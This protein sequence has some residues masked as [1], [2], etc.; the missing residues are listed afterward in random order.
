MQ[1][2]LYLC[3]IIVNGP[4]VNSM[5]AP[6]DILNQLRS[7]NYPS[8][9]LL[10]GEEPYYIDLVSDY[11]EHRI[12]D[13]AAQAFDLTVL[14]GRDLPGQDISPAVS[15]ARGFAMMGGVKIVLVKEAQVIKKWD[16][17]ALYMDNP[18]PGTLFAICYKYGAPDKRLNLWKSFEKKG[19]VI[20]ASE[21]L[22]DY[23]VT[24]WIRD[25]LQQRIRQE[26]LD[27]RFQDRVPDQLASYIGSDL[28]AIVS[29]VDKLLLGRPADCKVIDMNLVERNVGI[30]KDFNVF[31]LQ[32]ALVKGDV[33]K[34]NRIT[35]YFATGK[36]H[37]MIKELGILFSFFQNLML[38][39]YLPDKNERAVASALKI[40]P[41]F[42]KD[43]ATAARRY[44]AYK[45]LRIIGYF[46]DTDARL[47]GL[48]NPSAKD[49]DLWKELIY[50]ILH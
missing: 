16:A 10:A 23:K 28:S 22:R 2:L 34:A 44:S 12:L 37:P 26:G 40:S 8:V 39:H 15:A 17:L 13:E 5:L 48:N 24:A 18:Q 45:T 27:L 46:R 21:K 50:K 9:C 43:Y 42:V 11:I 4:I 36:D 41:Y 32:D 33:V 49:E 30:S 6:D 31:E 47:K 3:M 20:M 7:G 29:A 38:Y 19:G 35:Q 25:Y 1:F 14:Y